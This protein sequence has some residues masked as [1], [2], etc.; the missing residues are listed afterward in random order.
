LPDSLY[1]PG[2]TLSGD[3]AIKAQREEGVNYAK[4]KKSSMFK[5]IIVIEDDSSIYRF[6]RKE[7]TAQ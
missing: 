2:H 6:D 1:F 7:K 5:L 3:A 4:C